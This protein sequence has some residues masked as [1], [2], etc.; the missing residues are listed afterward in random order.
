MK[1]CPE[2]AGVFSGKQAHQGKSQL[3]G[4]P[5]RVYRAIRDGRNQQ[6]N[7]KL[8]WGPC[9]CCHFLVHLGDAADGL[10]TRARLARGTRD[11]SGRL[12][13]LPPMIHDLVLWT[14]NRVRATGRDGTPEERHPWSFA[15]RFHSE[16]RCW[17]PNMAKVADARV[18][19]RAVRS[20]ILREIEGD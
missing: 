17:T 18:A 11:S 8:P 12:R 2:K 7:W 1:V 13:L 3:G 9:L 20:V 19:A 15:T 10:A 5:G 16:H 6:S 4:E 14:I